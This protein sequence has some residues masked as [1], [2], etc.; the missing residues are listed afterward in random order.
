MPSVL[1]SVRVRITLTATVVTA[2]AVLLAGSWLVRTVEGSL[3][4]GVR[5]EEDARLEGPPKAPRLRNAIL[6]PNHRKAA[7]ANAEADTA[8]PYSASPTIPTPE[9][10]EG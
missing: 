7:E 3:T 10:R 9:P 8:C 1:R 5:T 6:D 2:I 4:D